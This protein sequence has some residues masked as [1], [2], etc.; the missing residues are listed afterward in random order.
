MKN[1]HASMRFYN[2]V[3]AIRFS[4]MERPGSHGDSSLIMHSIHGSSG[5]LDYRYTKVTQQMRSSI[6]LSARGALVLT[7]HIK[8]CSLES[9]YAHPKTAQSIQNL[10]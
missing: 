1:L 10:P 9:K 6:E 5:S 8:A 3:G 7:D 2:N 4:R